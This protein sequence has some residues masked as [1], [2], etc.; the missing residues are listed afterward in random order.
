MQVREKEST[1][2]SLWITVSQ[3]HEHADDAFAVRIDDGLLHTGVVTTM[4]HPA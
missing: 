2:K 1:C 3:Y 4:K